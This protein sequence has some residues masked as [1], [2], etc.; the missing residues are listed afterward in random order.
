MH[1]KKED[2]R[3]DGAR[4]K[5]HPHIKPIKFF[6]LVIQSLGGASGHLA[7]FYIHSDIQTPQMLTPQITPQKLT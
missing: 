5:L 2:I 3:R 7:F 1:F 6:R 4:I